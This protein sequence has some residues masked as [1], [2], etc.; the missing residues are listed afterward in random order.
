[1][2]PQ[3]KT[4]CFFL[5]PCPGGNGDSVTPPQHLLMT[6]GEHTPIMLCKVYTCANVNGAKTVVIYF[7]S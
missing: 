6:S 4:P 3:T 1:M 2:L 5:S 7:I